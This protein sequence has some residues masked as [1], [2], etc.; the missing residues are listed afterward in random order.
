MKLTAEK[1]SDQCVRDRLLDAADRL[2]YEAGVQSVGID[3]VIAEAGAAKASLYAHFGSKDELIA[4]YMARRASDAREQMTAFSATVPPAERALR[5]FDWL[6]RWVES[7]EFRGCP[8]QRVVSELPDPAHPARAI[9]A[10]QRAW[11]ESQFREWVRDAGAA[12]VEQTVGALVVLFDGAVAAS[13][14]DGSQR[15][16]HARWAAQ[17][18][19]KE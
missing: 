18:L 5:I 9:V 17:Q 15:A 13:E 19:L 3:R 11:T 14:L 6:V 2:F 16:H 10:E 7:P 1:S 4:A 8:L 12:N